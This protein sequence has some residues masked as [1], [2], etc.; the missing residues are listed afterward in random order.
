MT[1]LV[2]GTSYHVRAFVVTS[3]AGTQRVDYGS[4]VNFTTLGINLT[5]SAPTPNTAT[6][7]SAQTFTTTIT[8]N[9]GVSTGVGFN[10]FFQVAS[11]A[12][13]GGTIVDKAP[14]AMAILAAGGTNTATVSHTFATDGTYSLRACADKS[15]ALNTGVITETNEGDNCSGWTD[16]I[17]ATSNAIPTVTTPTSTSLTTS[18]AT[19]GANV[20]S[21][22]IPAA[23]T[24]RG[25]CWGT[26]PSPITNCL[27]E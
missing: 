24:A 1:G 12:G 8:N 23:I 22:G 2:P 26:T 17:V 4:E 5:A 11:A 20:T 16:V 14:T 7:N 9:G 25:T 15:S 13:G 27:S 18:G 21:L 6:A 3:S 10:N 19:L